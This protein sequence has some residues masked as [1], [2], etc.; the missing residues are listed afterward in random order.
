MEKR[1]GSSEHLEQQKRLGLHYCEF[2]YSP[3]VLEQQ[4]DESPDT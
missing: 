1:V 3:D 2:M 4:Y